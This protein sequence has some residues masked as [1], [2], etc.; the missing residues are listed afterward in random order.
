MLLDGLIKI[1]RGRSPRKERRSEE[2]EEKEERGRC[3]K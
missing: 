3:K 2:K 1:E